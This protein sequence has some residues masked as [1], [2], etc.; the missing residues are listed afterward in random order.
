MYVLQTLLPIIAVAPSV[1][2]DYGYRSYAKTWLALSM[3]FFN[4]WKWTLEN[5]TDSFEVGINISE[6]LVTDSI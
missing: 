2:L 4:L 3:L 5:G 1:A 6:F